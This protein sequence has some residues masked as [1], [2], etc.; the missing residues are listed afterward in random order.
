M[1]SS[2]LCTEALVASIFVESSVIFISLF[3]FEASVLLSSRSH[4]FLWVSSFFCSS[5]RRK[6]SFWTMFTT[7]SKGPARCA[8]TLSARRSKARECVSC[9]VARSSC[10]ARALGSWLPCSSSA[11]ATGDGGGAGLAGASVRTPVTSDM[12]LIA[13]FMASSS[14]ARVSERSSHSDFLTAQALLVCESVAVSACR[15]CTVSPRR[16]SSCVRS[17][18]VSLSSVCFVVFDAVA[19]WMLS[20]RAV[21][22]S[23]NALM[24]LVSPFV[25]SIFWSSN[26]SFSCFSSSMTVWDLNSYVSMCC[27]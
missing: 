4:Q 14:L 24:E 18:W 26:L 8:A 21:F 27:S 25:V 1:S 15:S 13:A 16:P 7:S 2:R 20:S 12:I 19:F 6:I 5:M 10:T 23:S 11:G 22:A 3:S 9:A 17:F